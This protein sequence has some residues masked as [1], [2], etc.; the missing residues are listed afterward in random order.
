[1]WTHM[2]SYLAMGVPRQKP[3]ESKTAKRVHG[4]DIKMLKIMFMVHISDVWAITV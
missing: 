3:F 2:Y 4:V 1:M